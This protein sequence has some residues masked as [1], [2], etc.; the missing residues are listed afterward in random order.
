[1]PSNPRL[2]LAPELLKIVIRSAAP[3][4]ER[5]WT[6]A[7]SAGAFT[8]SFWN[9]CAQIWETVDSGLNYKAYNVTTNCVQSHDLNMLEM[10]IYEY[11]HNFQWMHP[12]VLTI[13]ISLLNPSQHKNKIVDV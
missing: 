13:Q 5:M 3:G 12:V 11:I 4:L 10:A 1:V 9:L 7:G 2:L 6:Q 8:I